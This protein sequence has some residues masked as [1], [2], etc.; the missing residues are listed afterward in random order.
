MTI[1]N[2][3]S[4]KT[5][6]ITPGRRWADGESHWTGNESAE[7]LAQFGYTVQPE[8]PA[9]E[10]EPPAPV[11][12]RVSKLNLRR[13][14]R[15]LALEDAFDAALAANPAWARDWA[16]ATELRSDDPMLVAALPALAQAAGM[17]PE[18]A[19]ALLASAQI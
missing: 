16:D 2:T 13:A 19:T 3:A 5:I 18:Q 14:L 4:G 11:V 12:V 17:T 10:P 8:P 15:A 6:D 7:T 1:L 9:A